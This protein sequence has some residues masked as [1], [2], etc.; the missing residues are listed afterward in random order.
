MY[1]EQNERLLKGLT[2]RQSLTY[3]SKLKNSDENV[4]I[5]YKDVISG[6]L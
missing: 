4:K 2:V 1:Q 3:A 5:K 6:I